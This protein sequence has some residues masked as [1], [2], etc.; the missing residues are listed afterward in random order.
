MTMPAAEGRV[1]TP[2]ITPAWIG[3]AAGIDPARWI[4]QL[5]DLPRTH[6]GTD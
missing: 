2:A 5:L 3:P 4:D 6:E 1:L